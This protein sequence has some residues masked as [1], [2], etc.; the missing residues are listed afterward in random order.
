MP[1][2]K[3]P[4][5]AQLIEQH[6]DFSLYVDQGNKGRW[7]WSI[8]CQDKFFCSGHPTGWEHRGGAETCGNIVMEGLR[9]IGKLEAAEHSV[10][11]CIKAHKQM[12][13]DLTKADGKVATT[14]KLAERLRF[15]RNVVI[16]TAVLL[17]IATAITV[18]E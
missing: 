2:R 10:K 12:L 5:T 4:S 15:Q 17:F 14:K 1:R 13:D 16:I 3:E 18:A 9:C 8:R 11:N 7:R 6:G